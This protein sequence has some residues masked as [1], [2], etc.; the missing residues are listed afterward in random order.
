ML[1]FLLRLRLLVWLLRFVLFPVLVFSLAF[2]VF[3][4]IGLSLYAYLIVK[5]VSGI[6]DNPYLF[7]PLLLVEM[8]I[9][10]TLGIFIMVY[11][12]KVRYK[13]GKR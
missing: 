13:G 11:I 3:A 2:F 12:N 7:I 4:V 6:G 5:T 10:A 9:L 8:V 1:Q